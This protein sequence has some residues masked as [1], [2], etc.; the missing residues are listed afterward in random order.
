MCVTH[1]F[2]HGLQR[3][4]DIFSAGKTLV[5]WPC[6]RYPSFARVSVRA[7]AQQALQSRGLLHTR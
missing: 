6:T 3:S 7:P 4:L 5:C 1:R 2:E